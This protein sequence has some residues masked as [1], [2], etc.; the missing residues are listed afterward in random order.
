MKTINNI[1]CIGLLIGITSCNSFLDQQ[2]KSQMTLQT[3]FTTLA[4]GQSAVNQLYRDGFPGLYDAGSAYGGPTI[5]MGGYISGIFDNQYKGQ[6]QIVLDCQKL[7]I[8]PLRN[9]DALEGIWQ[10]CYTAI[11]RANTAIKYVPTIPN[12]SDQDKNT[13]LA[14]AKFFRAWN[15]FHLVKSFG[16]IPLIVEPTESLDGLDV[17]RTSTA[18]VYAQIIQDL[19]DAD[20]SGLNTAAFMNNGYRVTTGTV[21]TV[22][23]Q[24]YLQMSGYPLQA[25]H[26][27]DAANMARKVINSGV[28]QL[29]MHKD[30]QLNSAYNQIRTSNMNLAETIYTREYQT[31]ISDGGWWPT[32]A[33]PTG[34]APLFGSSF[35]YAI[36]NL[37]YGAADSPDSTAIKWYEP[38]DLRVQEKQY[39][40]RQFTYNNNGSDTTVAIVPTGNWFYY[41]ANACFTTGSCSQA[42]II[43]R[44]PEVLLIAAEAIAQSEGVTSEAINDLAQ[45]RARAYPS[46]PDGSGYQADVAA[47]ATTLQGLSVSDFVK[48]VWTEK[49]REFA[50]EFKIW[51]DIQR[52]RQYPVSADN[53]VV[54]FVNVV[55][56]T[57]PWNATFEEKHLLWPIPA[58]E[59]QRNPNLQQN[60]GY[61]LY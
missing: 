55:G 19:T 22:L 28:Y 11:N 24:V 58:D 12:I 38:K 53:G 50:L 27:A 37:T 6:E 61:P 60:P 46:A 59:M 52:T 40:F 45:V 43:L 49:L 9:E 39:F 20:N 15:Y 48:Q 25:N 41:D 8:D 33:F 23:A 31:G 1:L 32:Y 51:D 57:T 18:D 2:P 35:K 10:N 44:Y 3:Y 13:L 5:M 42:K 47:I 54:T 29:T 36:T 16:D 21:E 17:S 26:Y 4:Q 34:Y 14:Q 56:A 30:L 7:L